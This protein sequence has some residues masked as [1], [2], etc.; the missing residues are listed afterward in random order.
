[1]KTSGVFASSYTREGP[2]ISF[3]TSNLAERCPG[4]QTNNRAEL[5]VC[6]VQI[7][8]RNMWNESSLSRQ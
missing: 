8:W 2:Y 1:M 6:L 5:I 3:L 4:E 7:V